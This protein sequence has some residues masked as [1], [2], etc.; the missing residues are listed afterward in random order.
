MSELEKY[1]PLSVKEFYNK[2]HHQYYEPS[3]HQ[4]SCRVKSVHETILQQ[5]RG[6]IEGR[7]L[8]VGC[9]S[10]E[11]PINTVGCDLSI[12]GL[13][14]SRELY[15]DSS[16]VCADINY[17]PFKRESFS[18][19]LAGLL[20]DHVENLELAFFSL[21][22]VAAAQGRLIVTVFDSERRPQ[23]KYG[24]DRLQYRSIDGEKY[25]VP[26]YGWTRQELIASSAKAGWV[27]TSDAVH[28]TGDNDYLLRQ[29]DFEAEE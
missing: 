15:P 14:L 21:R 27:F 13:R 7:I 4:I 23:N 18:A 12:E 2:I 9:A 28:S 3:S 20:L 24:G 10:Q 19:I 11:P 6:S 16:S 1:R 5:L 17:L 8:D 25:S 26:S 22:G 29:L